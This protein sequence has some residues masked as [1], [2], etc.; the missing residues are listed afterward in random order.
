MRLLHFGFQEIIY[1]TSPFCIITLKL[2]QDLKE[3]SPSI[4]DFWGMCL[5]IHFGTSGALSYILK[6]K[7]KLFKKIFLNQSLNTQLLGTVFED[8]GK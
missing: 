5:R 8:K 2:S 7:K 1:D 3:N 6:K 4:S